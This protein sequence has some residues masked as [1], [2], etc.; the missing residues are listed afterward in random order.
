M[1]NKSPLTLAQ[2]ALATAQSELSKA[3]DG[4]NLTY[5]N[6]CRADVRQAEYNLNKILN[7]LSK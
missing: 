5:V 7:L 6:F 2:K 4:N 3:E 1:K